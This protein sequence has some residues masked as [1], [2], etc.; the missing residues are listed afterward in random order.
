MS[1]AMQLSLVPEELSR[2]CFRGLLAPPLLVARVFALAGRALAVYCV[3]AVLALVALFRAQPSTE[4]TLYRWEQT[5]AL[6]ATLLPCINTIL[7]LT[8]IGFYE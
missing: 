8:S 7:Y 1:M 2:S 3:L 6:H 5:Q 4:G